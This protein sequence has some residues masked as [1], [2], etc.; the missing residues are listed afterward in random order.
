MQKIG[1]YKFNLSGNNIIFDTHFQLPDDDGRDPYLF[2]I[3]ALLKAGFVKI[4]PSD[5]RSDEVDR[6]NQA[7][8]KLRKMHIV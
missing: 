4:K 2:A 6:L 7:Q 8:K 1:L 5:L 3:H